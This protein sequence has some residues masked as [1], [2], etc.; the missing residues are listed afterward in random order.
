M[1]AFAVWD[2]REKTLTLVRDRTGIK[3]LYYAKIGEKFV[4]ASEIKAILASKLVRAELDHEGL[5]QFLTFL[6]TVHEKTLFKGIYQLAARAFSG[7]ERRRNL[8]ERMV[9]FG[10]FARRTRA[11]R[12]ISGANRF[13]KLWK[14]RC[15][16][17]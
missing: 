6:W 16:W 12:K 5:H 1:F 7:L 13:W 17:K 14:E 4:F 3:P 2:E 10:F 15:R 11:N 8:H 9:G